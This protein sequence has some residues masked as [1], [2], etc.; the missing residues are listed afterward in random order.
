MSHSEGNPSNAN[1]ASLAL[2]VGERMVTREQ[3][4]GAMAEFDRRGLREKDTIGDN[5]KGWSVEHDGKRYNPKWLLKLATETSLNK[6]HN[7]QAIETL[8][9]LGFELRF[10]Q[11]GHG[12]KSE[13]RVLLNKDTETEDAGNGDELTFD[14][15]RNLQKA[16]RANI[17]QLE[18]GLKITDGG[19][20]KRIE[21]SDKPEM[22]EWGY[23]DITAEDS[24]G[25]TVVI[26]LKADEAGRRAIGQILGYMGVLAEGKKQIRGI[27]V[28]KGF[29]PQAVAAAAAVPNLK[30]IKYS[31]NF[32]FEIARSSLFI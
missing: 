4:F 28:A 3:V 14:I 32:A 23:V 13:D 12:K 22:A 26:E 15:E 1:T 11:D 17:G 8:K 19:R 18:A 2:T 25:A 16:L 20:E 31:F 30:L 27:L 9:A 10:D 7:Q 21:Y 6:F 5:K 29:S 24:T